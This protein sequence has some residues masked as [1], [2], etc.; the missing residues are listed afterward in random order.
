MGGVSMQRG[1]RCVQANGH[2]TQ[3]M[4]GFSHCGWKPGMQLM[5][6]TWVCPL[7]TR[8]KV[9]THLPEAGKALAEKAAALA[10]LW[11]SV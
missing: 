9:G 6:L 7:G 4:F 11:A 10:T 8:T 2:Q 5:M 3:N 1:S